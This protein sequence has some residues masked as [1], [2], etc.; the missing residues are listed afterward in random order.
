MK[1][2]KKGLPAS[3][4]GERSLT[5]TRA[6]WKHYSRYFGVVVIG[7]LNLSLI[8]STIQI[9]STQ[10]TPDIDRE[11]LS[12]ALVLFFDVSVLIPL[13]FE[14]DQVWATPDRIIFKTLF[15]TSKVP[16]GEIKAFHNPLYL[17]FA[18]VRTQRCFYLINKRDIAPLDQLLETIQ[19]KLG[20]AAS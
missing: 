10:P 17:A 13:I 4:S 3:A 2:K 1:K 7:L 11:L 16:W 14:V 5:F 6:R 8:A 19:F 12:F 18:I 20:K 9:H 15:W